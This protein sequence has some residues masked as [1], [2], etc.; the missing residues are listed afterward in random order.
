MGK[1]KTW[2]GER[3]PVRTGRKEEDKKNL[4]MAGN[5]MRHFI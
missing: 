4:E 5:A 2:K 1:R 3:E